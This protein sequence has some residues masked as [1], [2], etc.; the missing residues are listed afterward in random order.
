MVHETHYSRPFP[1]RSIVIMAIAAV[2]SFG[3]YAILPFEPNPSKG[4]ALLLFIAIMWLTEAV[5]ITITALMV[6]ILGVLI[7]VGKV[8]D[9]KFTPMTIKS[10]MATFADPTIYVFFGGFALAAALHVQKLD[11]KLA[12][13]LISKA[14]GRLG[15]SAILICI[16]TAFLS[17]WVS[18]TA[19]AAIMLPLAL[20]IC[21][22]MDEKDRGTK[23]FLLIGIAYSAS[24]G[25]LGTLVG[26]PPN[27]IAA[28]ELD[29]SFFDWFKV[30]L[31]IM[32]ILFPTMLAVMYFAFKPNLNYKIEMKIEQ[33]PWNRDR[34][35]TTIVFCITAFLWIFSKPLNGVLT[36]MGVPFRLSDAWIAIAAAISVVV[37]GLATWKEVSDNT[38]W[39]VLLLFG[40]GLTL[41]AILGQ[42]GASFVLGNAVASVIGGLPKIVV[43]FCVALFIIGTTE[44]TSNTASAALLV[45]VFAAIADSLGMPKETLVIIIGIGASCAF[46]MPVATPPNALVFGTGEIKQ[47]DLRRS[48]LRLA[49]CA[50]I[51]LTLYTYIFF[52]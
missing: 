42:T 5:H 39:G 34:V 33:I 20:G 23:L 13:W 45:P 9:G 19:T 18:N 52:A 16:A 11:R 22:N 41:S 25:G 15:V 48:G 3:L 28:K 1:V 31:P 7:G 30:G 47:R 38:E 49:P 14:G 46:I 24:I 36:D 17:M 51:I 32:L 37:G 26:S 29:F 27:M 44:F 12:M 2:L 21:S 50:A 43:I 4:L 6:P 8:T 35:F 10:A 40:G